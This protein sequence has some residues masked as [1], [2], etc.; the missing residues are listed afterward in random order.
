[1][2]V[3]IQNSLA[4]ATHCFFQENGLCMFVSQLSQ[5]VTAKVL[6]KCS[7]SPL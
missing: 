6:V 3:G 5:P 4:F 7:K 2:T 1:M